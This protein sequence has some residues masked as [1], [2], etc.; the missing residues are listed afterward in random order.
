[1]CL[2]TEGGAGDYFRDT[3]G[4]AYAENP[5]LFLK[6]MT[7]VRLYCAGRSRIWKALRLH[8][9]PQYRFKD[10]YGHPTAKGLEDMT[11]KDLQCFIEQETGEAIADP[12]VIDAWRSRLMAEDR[13]SWQAEIN[14]L[15]S[16]FRG[17]FR[18]RLRRRL[19]MEM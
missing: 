3:F 17:P 6:L 10:G 7:R 13:A 15:C 12:G 8:R 16:Y 5:A 18:Q 2:A 11:T 4:K 14:R 19:L 1:M 9:E